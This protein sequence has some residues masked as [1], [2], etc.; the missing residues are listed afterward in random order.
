[1]DRLAIVIPARLDSSRFPAKLL[2]RVAGRTILEWTWSRAVAARGATGVWIATDS[3]EIELEAIAFGAPVIRTGACATGTDRVAAAIDSI[4][5]APR[6]VIDLQGDEPRIEPTV[7]ER[8][9]ERLR[10]VDEAIVTCGSPLASYEDWIDPDVVKVVS[11]ADG[12]A[13]SF[14]RLPIPG[15]RA[16]PD[17]AAFAAVRGLVLQHIGLYG[18]PCGLLRRFL[19][20]SPTKLE[21]VEGLEQW[22]ALEAGIPILVVPVEWSAPSIDTPADLERARPA[23]EAEAAS[24]AP[25]RE[26]GPEL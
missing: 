17:P 16:R 3:A 14:S 7:I 11:A 24:R 21:V 18:F 22:R 8:V 10:G 5:P 9:A 13:L 6:W 26:E 19:A 15:T 20:L 2:R 4:R 1:M 23:L 25:A 12:R